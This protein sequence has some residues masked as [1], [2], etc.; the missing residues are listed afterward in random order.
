MT[1]REMK[2]ILDSLASEENGLS[3]FEL[4]IGLMVALKMADNFEIEN[5]RTVV[6]ER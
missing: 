5:A 1:D 4:A 2:K 3:D 6:S